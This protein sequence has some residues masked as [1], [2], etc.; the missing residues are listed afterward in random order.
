MQEALSFVTVD[1]TDIDPDTAP[2]VAWATAW[3]T[4]VMAEALRLDPA[5]DRIAWRSQPT[6]AAY[7]IGTPA[8]VFGLRPIDGGAS[9][10]IDEIAGGWQPLGAG[11]DIAMADDTAYSRFLPFGDAPPGITQL[12]IYTPALTGDPDI[13]AQSIRVTR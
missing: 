10:Q 7:S 13:T 5:A 8:R 12:Y 1:V 3:A 4:A 9:Y 6:G 2:G 11:V